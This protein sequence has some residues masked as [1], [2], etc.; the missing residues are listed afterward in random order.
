MIEGRRD[1]AVLVP[2]RARRTLVELSHL[3]VLLAANVLVRWSVKRR[4]TT[5]LDGRRVKT[6]AS[7][8]PGWSDLAQA[9]EGS[10]D[11]TDERAV[12]G[13]LLVVEGLEAVEVVGAC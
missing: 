13:R 7:L 8:A 2:E 4:E 1:I 9:W 3:D 12:A 11:Q 5:V 10:L 6:A